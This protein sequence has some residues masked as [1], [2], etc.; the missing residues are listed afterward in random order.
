MSIS[1]LRSEVIAL[2]KQLV[3]LGREYPLGYHN[4]FRP[5]LKA[6]FMKNRNLTEEA[7]IKKALAF[8]EYIVKELEM[9]YYL[10]KYR[11]LRKRYVAG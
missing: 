11:A 5:K 1:P 4:F 7:D 3:Y 6:A 8:G 2:Y 10:R 9:M